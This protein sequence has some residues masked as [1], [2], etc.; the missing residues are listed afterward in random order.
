[1][2]ETSGIRKKGNIANELLPT[3][4]QVAVREGGLAAAPAA[5][6]G[7]DAEDGLRPLAARAGDDGDG[8]CWLA[9]R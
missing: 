7:D 1:M 3:T 8:F 6:D 5:T 4:A 9:C 2:E